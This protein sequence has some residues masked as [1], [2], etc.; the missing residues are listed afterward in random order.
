MTRAENVSRSSNTPD[1]I[2]GKDRRSLVA[3]VDF[4]R[5]NRQTYLD[6]PPSMLS[7]E[8]TRLD[9][10]LCARRVDDE[11]D[12]ARAA[13]LNAELLHHR[14]RVALRV[15]DAR[16]PL[17]ER[18]REVRIRRGVRLGEL[19][20]RGHDVDGDYAGRAERARDGH[21]EQAD[22]TRAEDDDGLGGLERAN[23]RD[24]VNSNREGL[25]LGGR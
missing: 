6:E 20:A 21:A 10:H 1:A 17:L 22:G 23:V 9:R 13:L 19:E 4:E 25:H 15:R 12:A 5:L 7:D 18:R 14:L 24:G 2:A 3:M 11:V 16:L 8:D